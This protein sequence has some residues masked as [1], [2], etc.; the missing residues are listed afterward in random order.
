MSTKRG[1]I[2]KV[3]KKKKELGQFPQDGVCLTAFLQY[4]RQIDRAKK[5]SSSEKRNL[6]VTDVYHK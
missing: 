5:M 4:Q 6:Y 3:G 2:E 1:R